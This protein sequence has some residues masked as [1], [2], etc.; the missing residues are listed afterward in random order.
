M[1]AH[2]VVICRLTFV[3]YYRYHSPT[4]I[5]VISLCANKST[6]LHEYIARLYVTIPRR[7]TVIASRVTAA[8]STVCN[9]IRFYLK[10]VR[11]DCDESRKTSVFALLIVV[12]EVIRVSSF[13]FLLLKRIKEFN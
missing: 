2:I 8:A 9:C 13:I 11:K 7:H 3:L 1:S 5:N 10:S 12:F 6:R 4:Y